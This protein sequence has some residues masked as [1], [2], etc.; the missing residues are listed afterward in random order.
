MNFGINIKL[1]ALPLTTS[2]RAVTAAIVYHVQKD[3]DSSFPSYAR[4]SK[5]SGAANKTISKVIRTLR[6]ADILDWSHRAN[7]LTGK[8][9]NEY[10]FV[11]EGIR[12]NRGKLSKANYAAIESKLKVARKVVTA[13]MAAESKAK[14]QS[15]NPSIPSQ[16]LRADTV[17]N[18]TAP[19][20]QTVNNDVRAVT[21]SEWSTIPSQML[22]KPSQML[23]R[24]NN[25]NVP[26]PNA[27]RDQNTSVLNE[28]Q[29]RFDRMKSNYTPNTTHGKDFDYLP[30]QKQVR[31]NK[32]PQEQSH[33]EWLADYG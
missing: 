28:S 12:F 15:N 31:Q 8:K 1:M 26:P 29:K 13:E 3:G 9:S 27:C 18:V 30:E 16:M 21:G 14:K 32:K 25:D 7:I 33:D 23:R 5:E 10:R 4:I 6:Y 20:S 2:E 19:K 24:S 11:F 17:T 22:S